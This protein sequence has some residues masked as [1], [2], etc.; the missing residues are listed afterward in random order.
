MRD[1]TIVIGAGLA[2]LSCAR[3]LQLA[4]REVLVLEASDAV[5]GRVRTDRHR[6]FLLDRGFQVYLD[7]YPK[8]G[9][10]LD[11]DSLD[12]H[13]FKPGALVFMGGRLHRLMD[14][15][16]CPVAALGSAFAPVGSLRDK[17]LTAKLRNQ[18][19]HLSVAE[20]ESRPARST[21]ERLRQFGF[22]ERMIDGFFRPFYGGIFLESELRTSSRM[23]DF[24]FKMFSEGSATLPAGGMGAIPEQLA[25]T[26]VA[27]TVQL[28]AR[29]ASIRPDGVGLDD[30][31]FLV[32]D[33]VVLATDATTAARLLPGAPEPDVTW[34]ST[35]ALYFSADKSPLAK[36]LIA[37][38]GTGRGLVN[39]VCVPSDI[40]PSYAPP[41]RSLVSV[42]LLGVPEHPDLEPR[43]RSELKGWFGDTV[44]GWQWLRSDRIR[45]ALPEQLPQ[46]ANPSST[47]PAQIAERSGVYLCGD[48]L[49]NPSIEGAI[50]SGVR[51]AET[52]CATSTC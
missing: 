43:V 48:Y 11:L 51:A 8:A 28:G 4:G 32:S 52:I 24:T 21:A 15:F 35:T 50:T 9:Q 33:R 45:H 7:A 46:S 26:L 30:G 1:R 44:D 6:G 14:P 37:L 27:G 2:G 13:R 39:H 10:E 41:E 38:N 16:R 3:H 22:S 34:R 29:V 40:A 31:Q 42:S 23:F 19:K 47:R 25:A 5:G 49:A 20:I 36:G 18:I 12:L 17:L